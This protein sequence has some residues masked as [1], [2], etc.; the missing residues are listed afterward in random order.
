[1]TTLAALAAS[2]TAAAVE[3]QGVGWAGQGAGIEIT[4]LDADPRP[5]LILMAYDNPPQANNF[6]YRVGRNVD[7]NGVTADWTAGFIRVDGVGWE[8]QGAGLAV[9]NLDADARPELVLMAYDAP[10]GANN[11]RYKIGWNLGPDG[12]ASRWD[13]GFQMVPGVGWEGQGADLVVTNLDDDPR[14]DMILMAYDAP[15][16]ANN[17]RYKVGWNLNAA[18]VAA[19]WDAGFF[20]VDG[21]G[22]EGQGAGMAVASLD[23]DPRPELLLMAYDNPA[24]A[25]DFRWKVGW[26]L[27]ASGR[28][29]RWDPGFR[30][31]PGLGWEGAGAGLAVGNLD[32]DPR[33]DLIFMAYDD[34]PQANNFRYVVR[35]N[36]AV[37]QN[38]W[39]EMDKLTA[40]A[41]PP[42]SA[43]RGG[44][45]FTLPDIYRPLGFAIDVRQHEAAIADPLPGACFS[46]ADLDNFR[47]TRMNDP[48]P[49]GSTAWHMH[50]A[51]VDCHTDGILG[52][53]YD[54]AQ[55]RG[56]AVFMG[57]FG[58]DQARI[59]RTTA[60]ELGHALCLYHSDG[61]AWRPGGPATGQGRTIMNQTGQLAGDWGY[62]WSAGSTHKVLD[63]SKRRWA[64]RSGFGFGVC[65]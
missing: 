45:S 31:V 46:D 52:I 20:M 43:V 60:H 11:F 48:P 38:V 28:A 42:A 63:R 10:A 34:P 15:G 1:L 3:V 51:I 55:R 62:A 35:L 21:V 23:A 61:D 22:W 6:R 8:G 53:M 26:N 5:D 50:A 36:E 9:T 29:Q 41:W 59:L 14:P 25:N 58:G 49:A 16:G 44:R 47:A 7:A 4:N 12:V 40:V 32:A 64:P 2:G 19:R 33:P 17:F 24:R 37:A 27:D 57:A 54:T 18:G 65:H 56:F 30:V 39:L 13:A